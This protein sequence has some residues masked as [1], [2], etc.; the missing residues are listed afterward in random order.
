MG[1]WR[2]AIEWS[3]DTVRNGTRMVRNHVRLVS[4]G[5]EKRAALFLKKNNKIKERLE[6]KSGNPGTKGK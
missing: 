1:W 5:A 2:A 4:V 3:R 6:K